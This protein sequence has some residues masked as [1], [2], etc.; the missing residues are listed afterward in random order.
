MWYNPIIKSLLRSPL[1]FTVSKN[2]MLMTYNGRRSGT[3]YTIPM[4]YLQIG[5]SLYTISDRERVWWRNLRGGT[6]VTLRLQG[7]DILAHSETT[8]DLAGVAETLTLY[9]Q[10]APQL[11]KYLDV[12]IGADGAPDAQDLTRLATAKVIVRSQPKNQ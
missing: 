4:N 2:M 6:E 10:K 3:S 8:E 9:L 11:A 12:Q 1:H 5:G 7:R